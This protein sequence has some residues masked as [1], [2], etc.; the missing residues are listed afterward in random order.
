MFVEGLRKIDFLNY[1]GFPNTDAAYTNFLNK[2]MNVINEI[3][4]TKEIKIKNNTQEWFDKEI[5]ELMY[6]RKNCS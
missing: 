6:A 3:A 5:A 4:P 1:E 2:L